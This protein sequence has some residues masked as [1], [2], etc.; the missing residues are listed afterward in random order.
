MCFGDVLQRGHFVMLIIQ[1]MH[2]I[3]LRFLDISDLSWDLGC[4]THDREHSSHIP[5]ATVTS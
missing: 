4:L 2:L 3:N 1:G 5:T